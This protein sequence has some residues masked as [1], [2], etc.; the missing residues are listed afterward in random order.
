VETAEALLEKTYSE[1]ERVLD[2]ADLK[3]LRETE[4]S[5]AG[6][7]DQF[8]TAEY[9]L[10]GGGSGGPTA[11]LACIEALTRHHIDDLNDAYGWRVDK[12]G[13]RKSG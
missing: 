4:Q 11:R 2:A 10:Y 6:Y 13:G 1:I 12:F 7:R 5:W 8:C 3:R 9:E